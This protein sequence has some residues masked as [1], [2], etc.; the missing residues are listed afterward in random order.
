M[1]AEE[2]GHSSEALYVHV[3]ILARCE[4]VVSGPEP[5]YDGGNTGALQSLGL[6]RECLKRVVELIFGTAEVQAQSGGSPNELKGLHTIEEGGAFL[7]RYFRQ[8]VGLRLDGLVTIVMREFDG[9]ALRCP[10]TNG[11]GSE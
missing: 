6:R 1:L 7:V 4:F 11:S 5:G 8:E 2:I 10:H 3:K 9:L